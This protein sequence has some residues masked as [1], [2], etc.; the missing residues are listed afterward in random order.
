MNST[1]EE[2]LERI[3]TQ[4]GKCVQYFKEND[5]MPE[6]FARIEA[7]EK[8]IEKLEYENKIASMANN[9]YRR[10]VMPCGTISSIIDKP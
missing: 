6:V 8:R 5:A 7:L 2:R 9:A 10:G 4:V 1:I 3:E